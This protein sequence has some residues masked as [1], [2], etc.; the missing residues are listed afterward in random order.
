[1][2]GEHEFTTDEEDNEDDADFSGFDE[3]IM[4][5]MMANMQA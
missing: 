4:I 2:Q 5:R 3:P 1:M